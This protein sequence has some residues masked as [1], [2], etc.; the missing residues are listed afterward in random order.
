LIG[1]NAHAALAAHLR[2]RRPELDIQGAKY[3]DITAEQLA[4][5]D[6]YIGF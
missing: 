3:T 1:A 2:A 5:A 6:T 4:W